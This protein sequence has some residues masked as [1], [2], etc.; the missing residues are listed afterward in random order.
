MVFLTLAT[1][2][3]PDTRS[4]GGMLRGAAQNYVEVAGKG[5]HA[6]CDS[7]DEEVSRSSEM[8]A[9]NAHHQAYGAT[10]KRTHPQLWLYNNDSLVK[11]RFEEVSAI[12]HI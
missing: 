8:S 9:G 11:T 5:H 3:A 1:C 2:M 10:D 4:W 7:L 6:I 12:Q